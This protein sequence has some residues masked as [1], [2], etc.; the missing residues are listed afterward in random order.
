MACQIHKEIQRLTGVDVAN[1]LQKFFT[2]ARVEK[3]LELLR[4]DVK[5]GTSSSTVLAALGKSSDYDMN[6]KSL[7]CHLSCLSHQIVGFIAFGLPI[8]LH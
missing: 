3:F 1:K 4:R 6:S 7:F 2:P 5:G 8:T